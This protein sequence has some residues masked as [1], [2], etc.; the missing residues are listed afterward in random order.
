[1]D[2][3]VQ[4]PV[5]LLKRNAAGHI[6]E[7][8][9]YHYSARRNLIESFAEKGT[10]YYSFVDSPHITYRCRVNNS[11]WVLDSYSSHV[12]SLTKNYVIEDKI[13]SK[14]FCLLTSPPSLNRYSRRYEGII[15][16]EYKT[17][18]KTVL[19]E[20]IVPLI[21][22]PLLT[23]PAEELTE[24]IIIQRPSDVS[25]L[26]NIITVS[27]KSSSYFICTI[28]N[29]K[30]IFNVTDWDK[31]WPINMF[32]LEMLSSQAADWIGPYP[33]IPYDGRATGDSKTVKLLWVYQDR[34]Y[35]PYNSTVTAKVKKEH[36]ELLIKGKSY[37]N[38][39]LNKK[40]H[41]LYMLEHAPLSSDC[42]L[43]ITQ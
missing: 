3:V 37:T 24:D 2:F 27:L 13:E 35:S 11:L 8:H 34:K 41:V 15:T 25:V 17:L 43:S 12:D 7:L 14:P 19:P 30:V 42:H 1:M 32:E 29:S 23:V 33:L 9:Y 5:I 16:D 40:W 28:G 38:A 22:D 18:S 6:N 4:D 21:Y 39:S 10:P 26:T 36:G 20:S 31:T